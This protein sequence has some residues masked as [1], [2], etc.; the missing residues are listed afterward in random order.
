ML[1]E[2]FNAL[3]DAGYLENGRNLFL[4]PEGER[5]T[6]QDI[7]R[8]VKTVG[9][10]LGWPRKRILMA[11]THSLRVGG[12]WEHFQVFASTT[13][14]KQTAN[15]LTKKP[16]AKTGGS[17]QAKVVLKMEPRSGGKRHL[18]QGRVLT[19]PGKKSFVKMAVWSPCLKLA[20]KSPMNAAAV[21]VDS[22]GYRSNRSAHG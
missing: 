6:S 13:K 21:K 18:R 14:A 15:K 17:A 3:L 12:L 5:L 19:A 4:S 16:A 1:D 9:A 20:R 22:M 8:A 7:D 11:T 10:K 2:Y